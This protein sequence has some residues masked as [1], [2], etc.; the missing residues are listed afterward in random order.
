MAQLTLQSL[1]KR[2]ICNKNIPS[3]NVEWSSKMVRKM[4]SADVK[5]DVKQ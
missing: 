3:H 1:Y 5:S 4:I 2:K